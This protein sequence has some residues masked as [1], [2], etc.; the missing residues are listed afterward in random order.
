MTTPSPQQSSPSQ[1]EAGALN[2]QPRAEFA[3]LLQE[4]LDR[5]SAID[6]K[7]VADPTKPEIEPEWWLA[8]QRV[9]E[10]C[11]RAKARLA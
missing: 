1:G 6:F 9:R 10:E 11:Y 5:T 2:A 3:A 4:V 7:T 8:M